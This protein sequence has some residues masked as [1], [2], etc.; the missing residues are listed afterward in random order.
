MSVPLNRYYDEAQAF[1]KRV[2]IITM[3]LRPS[4]VITDTVS[5]KI[6]DL[7]MIQMI[8]NLI[9]LSLLQYIFKKKHTHKYIYIYIYIY[10]YV[11]VC[12]FLKLTIAIYIYIR[13]IS[14]SNLKDTI[15]KWIQIRCHW[16]VKFKVRWTMIKRKVIPNN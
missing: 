3:K 4:D 15:H 9:C 6:K 12:V 16:L 13:Y 2:N 11:D 10:I 7:S 5:I 1:Y 14:N 8:S